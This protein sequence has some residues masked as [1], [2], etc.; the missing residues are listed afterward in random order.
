MAENNVTW[1]G[2]ADFSEECTKLINSYFKTFEP[3]VLLSRGSGPEPRNWAA[4]GHGVTEFIDKGKESDLINAI[5]LDVFNISGILPHLHDLRDKL[6]DLHYRLE[7]VLCVDTGSS[8]S[9]LPDLAEKYFS[10]VERILD[11]VEAEIK[12]LEGRQAMKEAMAEAKKRSQENAE[13]KLDEFLSQFQELEDDEKPAEVTSPPSPVK[14]PEKPAVEAGMQRESYSFS[15]DLLAKG[16]ECSHILDMLIQQKVLVCS[17]REQ[18][19]NTLRTFLFGGQDL[20]CYLT[21]RR[22]GLPGLKSFVSALAAESKN[23]KLTYGGRINGTI[24]KWFKQENGNSI[25]ETTMRGLDRVDN[26]YVHTVQFTKVENYWTPGN[27]SGETKNGLGYR[28]T[29]FT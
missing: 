6:D 25:G 10:S 16:N 23:K 12:D 4:Y 2:G 14:V 22:G 20:G 26:V 15:R 3:I 29:M 18:D 9:C 8:G 13:N 1:K 5:I 19:L 24:Q 11:A 27:V 21:V 17:N 7:V 28:K